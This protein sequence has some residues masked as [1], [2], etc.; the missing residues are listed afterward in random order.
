[1]TSTLATGLDYA[2]IDADNHYY[3]SPDCFTRHI[4]AKYRDKAITAEKRDNG[5]WDVRIG[6]EPYTFFEPKFDKTNPPGSLL[7]ILRAKDTD[8]NFKWSDSYSADNM[9]PEYQD[10][11]LRLA[12][13]DEQGIE[14]TM[15]FPSFGVSVPHLMVDDADQMYANL[16]AFNRWLEEEWGYGADGRIFSPPMISMLD[17]DRA[18]EELDRV[19]ALGAKIIAVPPGPLG[20]G[21]S[22]ADPVFDPFWSRMNEAG[23]VLSLHLGDYLYPEISKLWGEPEDPPIRE[24]TAFQFAFT[25]G[26]RPVMEMFG[27]LIYG[28]MFARFPNLRVISIENGSDWVPY[29]L[30]LMDKKKGMGRYGRWI[31]GRPKGRPSEIFKEHCWV[32][33]YPED[34]IDAVVDVLGADRVL[35]GS[36]FPHPE[37][38]VQP[39]K[40]AE[41]MTRTPS[42][43]VKKVMRDNAAGL[44]GLPA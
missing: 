4:E 24:M 27:Q 42:D 31:G 32:A 19:L 28:N 2:V 25:Q 7:T 18:V 41:L 6:G 34:D 33:P 12:M 11:K 5:T 10:K 26:D 1:M 16:R 13:M 36:D 9:L 8:P 39:A 37:G 15:M 29:L 14:A 30:R 44:L 21:I 38:M 43:G 3:E 20:N 23:T 35:F 40:F 17:V 22:P